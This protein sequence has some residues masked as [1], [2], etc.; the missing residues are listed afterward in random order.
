VATDAF[1]AV[2]TVAMANTN[3]KI[4]FTGTNFFTA[5]Y[6]AH[7]SYAGVPATSVAI[8][9]A[10][11]VTATWTKGVPVASAAAVPT[12][13]FNET[14]SDLIH[15]ASIPT[16]ATVAN[17][18]SVTQ[19]TAAVSCSFAG[20]CLY[21]VTAGGV[22]SLLA[23]DSRVNNVTVCGSVCQYSDADSSATVAKCKLP[24]ISTVY[25]NANFKIAES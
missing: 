1:P 19:S 7:V 13:Y 23:S 9:S 22:A 12:L 3:D 25:S 4:I 10:T 18:L 11:Q 8:D 16:T 6:T 21:E 24:A 5:S 15:Y 17:A 20:G 14:S 2:T